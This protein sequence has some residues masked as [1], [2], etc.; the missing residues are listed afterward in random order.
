MLTQTVRLNTKHTYKKLNARSNN[1]YLYRPT[2]KQKLEIEVK[3]YN[4]KA[5]Y[6][7]YKAKYKY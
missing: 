4:Y 2:Q 3:Y 1:D 5:K 6:N 7:N